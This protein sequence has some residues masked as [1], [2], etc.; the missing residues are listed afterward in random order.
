M[1]VVDTNVISEAMKPSELCSP[2]VLAWLRAQDPLQVFTTAVNVAEILV[3]LADMPEGRRRADKIAAAHRVLA[4]FE[5]R[6]LA[7]DH[8]CAAAYAA[9]AAAR[10]PTQRRA[11][12]LDLQIAAIARVHGMALATRNTSD[13]EGCGVDLIDPWSGPQ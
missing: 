1:I 13:F 4:L 3:G 12:G 8:E 7:F 5:G 9:V 10:Q 11:N 2:S 6:V